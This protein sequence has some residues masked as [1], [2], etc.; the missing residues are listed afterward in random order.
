MYP[1]YILPPLDNAGEDDEHEIRK[2]MKFLQSFLNDVKE[3]P[4]IW[5]SQYV[6]DFMSLKDEKKFDKIFKEAEKEKEIEK[7]IHLQNFEGKIKL[8][9]TGA[10]YNYKE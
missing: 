3:V 1:G 9:F 4:E 2:K 10:S 5:S 6:V 7:I 8:D